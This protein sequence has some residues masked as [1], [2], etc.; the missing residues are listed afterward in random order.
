MHRY[1]DPH[2]MTMLRSPNKYNVYDKRF[3]PKPISPVMQQHRR[4]PLMNDK[5]TTAGESSSSCSFSNNKF[6]NV[7]TY[8]LLFFL[9]LL[10][11]YAIVYLYRIYT[12]K[13]KGSEKFNQEERNK[14]V[15]LFM[16]GCPHCQTFQPV[17]EAVI[18]EFKGSPEFNRNWSVSIEHDTNVARK[19]YNVTSFPTVVVVKNN[20][21]AEVKIGSMSSDAFR[22]FVKKH[23]GA[24]IVTQEYL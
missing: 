22:T 18:G 3:S 10:I 12:S 19:Q 6:N 8:I 16:P 1:S 4:S 14:I 23:V 24:G 20:Q 21:V 2:A 7:F 5:F 13:N 17:F 9:V 11:C 15:A